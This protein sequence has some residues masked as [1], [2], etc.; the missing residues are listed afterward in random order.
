M[1]RLPE[2][3][4][5]K[6]ASVWRAANVVRLGRDNI[7]LAMFVAALCVAPSVAKDI[8]VAAPTFKGLIQAGDGGDSFHCNLCDRESEPLRFLG[9]ALSVPVGDG[10]GLQMD[11]AGGKL[12]DEELAAASVHLFTRDPNNLL[13]GAFASTYVEE[14]GKFDRGMLNIGVEAELYTGDVTVL[15]QAG[16]RYAE[17]STYENAKPFGGVQLKWYVLESLVVG[18]G[19]TSYR[20]NEADVTEQRICLEWL[21]EMDFV[22]GLAFRFDWNFVENEDGAMLAGVS[23]SFGSGMTLKHQD[24]AFMMSRDPLQ[25]WR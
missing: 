6:H 4:R 21:P 12:G 13:V 25:L 9:G 8:A 11:I 1:R 22:P 17:L 20:G 2:Y 7:M 24:R 23:Y 5:L 18:G 16:Y 3:G 10:L 15:A 14:A 19:V